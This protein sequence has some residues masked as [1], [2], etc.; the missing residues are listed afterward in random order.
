MRPPPSFPHSPSQLRRTRSSCTVEDEEEDDESLVRGGW[1]SS[2]EG[3][4]RT[5]KRTAAWDDHDE[6]G[7]LRYQIIPSHQGRRGE[8]AEGGKD[9]STERK[10][11]SLKSA[12]EGSADQEGDGEQ[13]GERAYAF[14]V[15]SAIVGHRQERVARRKG[16][17][18]GG[19][20]SRVEAIER[21]ARDGRASTD[22]ITTWRG[23]SKRESRLAPSS[24]HLAQQFW[25]STCTTF[26]DSLWALS[27]GSSLQ[28]RNEEEEAKESIP[29]LECIEDVSWSCGPCV[30]GGEEEGEKES[31][32]VEGV[33]GSKA[34][35]GITEGR[36]KEQEEEEAE[37]RGNDKN[38]ESRHAS[39]TFR[40]S[41][42]K[43]QK[44]E[45]ERF[46]Q[47]RKAKE[48]Q[49]PQY[50]VEVI[51]T[52][53]EEPSAPQKVGQKDVD[54]KP[55]GGPRHRER[56]RNGDN[57]LPFHGAN[58][59]S[60]EEEKRRKD[61]PGASTAQTEEPKVDDGDV[62]SLVGDEERNEDSRSRLLCG[63]TAMNQQTNEL[64][65]PERRG[66][67]EE[68]Q[69]LLTQKED[70]EA[71]GVEK[72]D[73]REEFRKETDGMK[74]SSSELYLSGEESQA[75]EGEQN[76][77]KKEK[78]AGDGGGGRTGRGEASKTSEGMELRREEEGDG[79][80][81]EEE[82]DK[83][84]KRRREEEEDEKLVSRVSQKVCLGRERRAAC[85]GEASCLKSPTK[86]DVPSCGGR[87]DRSVSPQSRRRLEI[88]LRELKKRTKKEEGRN[89]ISGESQAEPSTA[90]RVCGKQRGEKEGQEGRGEGEVEEQLT[91]ENRGLLRGTE[92]EKK[93]RF[94]QAICLRIEQGKRREGGE[95]E[96]EMLR[97]VR[98]KEGS[99]VAC[100]IREEDR[101][102][103]PDRAASVR[104]DDERKAVEQDMKEQEE[105]EGGP[106]EKNV[107]RGD[108]S[109]AEEEGEASETKKQPTFSSDGEMASIV[110]EQE[111]SVVAVVHVGEEQE[112]REK[113]Q[114]TREK[115]LKLP[116]KESEDSFLVGP[117]AD[118][119]HDVEEERRRAK[120]VWETTA[121]E[122]LSVVQAK[123]ESK[124]E[125][126]S[127]TPPN[128]GASETL[129]SVLLEE[130][131]TRRTKPREDEKE[132]SERTSN[133]VA[134]REES[135]NTLRDEGQRCWARPDDEEDAEEAV[136]RSGM[137]RSLVVEEKKNK[138]W[139]EEEEA[140]GERRLL[141][142]RVWHVGT[143]RLA[144][145]EGETTEEKE[146]RRSAAEVQRLRNE[147]KK[148]RAILLSQAIERAKRRIEKAEAETLRKLE[149]VRRQ[150]DGDASASRE[151]GGEELRRGEK[152]RSRKERK[153]EEEDEEKSWVRRTATE[154]RDVAAIFS[155]RSLKTSGDRETKGGG[156]CE[157]EGRVAWRLPCKGE[158]E[159][160]GKQQTHLKIL[161]EE[162]WRRRQLRE[163][164]R[165]RRNGHE[166][167]DEGARG[168]VEAD[169]SVKGGSIVRVQK[170]ERE[171]LE[172]VEKKEVA[173]VFTKK[174][175]KNASRSKSFELRGEKVGREE[176]EDVQGERGGGRCGTRRPIRPYLPFWK[177]P[178]E[179]PSAETQQRREARE[180]EI[181]RRK[182]IRE[183]IEEEKKRM[184]QAE[185]ERRKAIQAEEEHHRRLQEMV[186]AV[187]PYQVRNSNLLFFFF[188]G[189]AKGPGL[190]PD[191]FVSSVPESRRDPIV[192]IESRRRK[193][194][195]RSMRFLSAAQWVYVL[196][197]HGRELASSLRVREEKLRRAFQMSLFPYVDFKNK[198]DLSVPYLDISSLG[199]REAH[200]LLSLDSRRKTMPMAG[201]LI[202]P[203]G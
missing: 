36:K 8:E 199:Y 16:E 74:R 5:L 97:C 102:E 162:H 90:V 117:T 173:V 43:G 202:G 131:E 168:D 46:E 80:Q 58:F 4:A 33:S 22:E 130:K 155:R 113:K 128:F 85:T 54:G 18:E 25:G 47:E 203:F 75:L 64:A 198:G 42:E 100:Q 147:E 17:E 78:K 87:T 19:G 195:P 167:R 172:R 133:N 183:I 20:A 57:R 41:E 34:T 109:R 56:E 14:V 95:S 28:L 32:R 157:Q 66:E 160:D 120:A 188:L 184:D 145:R 200:G 62:I 140:K 21:A 143:R 201:S 63:S 35:G 166:K 191:L 67:E 92:E 121:K 123:R 136:Q 40:A 99:P 31:A 144:D 105:G 53:E 182:T 88:C 44:E 82:Q 134:E 159:E 104:E 164:E 69:G 86:G 50:Q 96:G 165:S 154:R 141:C 149:A 24:N 6:S 27:S 89:E 26:R 106:S 98:E 9:E 148:S 93:R 39:R 13:G 65:K 101:P 94:V 11:H 181:R 126:H 150:V 83:T 151:R 107:E 125:S 116:L 138:S 37:D 77:L 76:V 129:M 156:R 12:R 163:L 132:E 30:Q 60:E 190:F 139:R 72:M 68:E 51:G 180:Q 115:M 137:F 81:E 91:Q 61:L 112:V 187:I 110:E 170:V 175:V 152:A 189:S 153:E 84:R 119:R 48:Q 127:K 135:P 185:Q 52:E 171:G 15:P 45:D 73:S 108:Q 70:E 124:M 192:Y 169:V 194:S 174:K 118:V 111:I 178:E 177:Q 79:E 122:L 49:P 114:T 193:G 55:L 2:A 29:P 179:R 103:R 59:R 146:P 71:E 161:I 23:K 176:V 7:D 3:R 196:L 10:R 158:E 38:M 197:S 186:A 1:G 142:G